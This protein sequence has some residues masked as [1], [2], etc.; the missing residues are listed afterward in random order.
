MAFSIVNIATDDVSALVVGHNQVASQL[1]GLFATSA[2]FSGVMQV[3]G[4][5]RLS[6]TLTV[7]SLAIF[8]GPVSVVG[9]FTV[10]GT[11]NATVTSAGFATSAAG[12]GSQFVL[13]S[14][15]LVASEA[16]FS[17]P[18]TLMPATTVVSG[19][20]F[21][22]A[23]G[24]SAENVSTLSISPV[25]L[26]FSTASITQFH[27]RNTS[28]SATARAGLALE[29]DGSTLFLYAR[30]FGNVGSTATVP[31]SGILEMTA[32][33][34]SGLVIRTT[35]TSAPIVVATNNILRFRIDSGGAS[36]LSNVTVGS[37]LYVRSS[38]LFSGNV[39]IADS[40]VISGTAYVYGSMTV[41]GTLS[42]TLSGVAASAQFAT[43]AGH[44]QSATSAVF[45][46]S[47]TSAA[48]AQSTTSAAFAQ[49][50]TSAAHAG[51]ATV[52]TGVA[53]R[54]IVLVQ[55]AGMSLISSAQ[56]ALSWTSAVID[57]TGGVAW[58]TGG[59]V[60]VIRIPAGVSVVEF[61][62]TGAFDF[63]AA[64]LR[65]V[66]ISSVA[67]GAIFGVNTML[68]T[69]QAGTTAGNAINITSPPFLVSTG[70][71][72]DFSMRPGGSTSSPSAVAGAWFAMIVLA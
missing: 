24:I 1:S 15:L 55:S 72:F 18:V 26:A 66:N 42:A 2:V 5:T 32:A 67:S 11:V 71:T 44:A 37:S 33:S 25:I 3:S 17:A 48:F 31:N 6:S 58:S 46:Q 7:T 69:Q 53:F 52:A 34:G 43:S 23:H 70:D 4:A 60:S 47:A 68:V 29:D 14:T 40:A 16:T 41:V 38:A 27:L 22:L 45:A 8:S 19:M 35:G 65:R 62:A 12:F 56:R 21:L 57:T 10:T 28:T 64:G 39:M 50:A 36:V 20:F 9:S 30:G 54:G 49:S 13:S 63:D 59:N 51:S 61:R